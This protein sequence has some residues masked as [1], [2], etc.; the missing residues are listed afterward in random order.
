MSNIPKRCPRC[1]SADLRDIVYGTPDDRDLV[2]LW[3]AGEVMIRPRRVTDGKG[4]GWMC[5]ECGLEAADIRP[6]RPV[7]AIWRGRCG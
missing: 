6:A 1:G 5:G 4:P 7:P 2:H 3:A